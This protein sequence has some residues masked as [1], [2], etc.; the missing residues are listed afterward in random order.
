MLL[1]EA[2][3]HAFL[4]NEVDQ[5]TWDAVVARTRRAVGR[6]PDVARAAE[7][8]PA[9]TAIAN[10]DEEVLAYLVEQTPGHGLSRRIMD[11]MLAGLNKMGFSTQRVESD[12]ALLRRVTREMLRFKAR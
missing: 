10:R 8:V 1:H 5:A 6:D 11:A 4:R 9:D 12:A 3:I 2:G 7:A